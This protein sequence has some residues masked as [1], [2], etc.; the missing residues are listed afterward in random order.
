VSISAGFVPQSLQGAIKLFAANKW[1]PGGP[2]PGRTSVLGARW[3]QSCDRTLREISS[4]HESMSAHWRLSPA[5]PPRALN[6]SRP[7]AG[8]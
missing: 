7:H 2:V 6:S 3:C 8:Q 4:A 5:W 1:T